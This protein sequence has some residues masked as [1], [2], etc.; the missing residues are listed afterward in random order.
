MLVPKIFL[1]VPDQISDRC[2]ANEGNLNPEGH[3]RPLVSEAHGRREVGQR[4]DVQV[5]PML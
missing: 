2:I 3:V 4:P 1:E 5:R